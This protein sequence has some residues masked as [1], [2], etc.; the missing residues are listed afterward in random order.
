MKAYEI[1]PGEGFAGLTIVDRAAPALGAHDVRVRVHAVSLNYRDLVGVKNAGRLPRPII[2]ASDGAGE[3]VAIGADVRRVAVGQRV[4]ATFFPNWIEG[5][6]TADTFAGALGGD[7]DGMLA[8]E[9]VLPERAWVPIPSH[10]SYEEAATLP[11]AGVTAYA[12]LFVAASLRPGDSV[13]VQGSGGVSVFSLQL[14][15]AA[16]ARVI[17]TSSS[18]D[19]RARLDKMGAEATIDYKATPKWGDAARAATGGRGVDVVVEVGGAGTL[20][21]SIAAVRYAG[22]I[23]LLGVL[24]GTSGQVNT[25]GIFRKSIKV[26]GVYVGS[27]KTFEDLLRALTVSGIRPVIDAT[28]PFVDARAAFEHLASGKHFGKVVVKVA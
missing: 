9:V 23:S 8:E 14:A 2:P 24:A 3:V 6:P 17:A 11:C 19:K 27:R 18:A 16:G 1:H 7:V 12:A 28:F 10:L 13:L 21:Q 15:R 26:H 20:D 25:Y 22:T 4:A 5:E